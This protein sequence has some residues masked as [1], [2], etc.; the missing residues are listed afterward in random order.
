MCIIER[1]S[2]NFVLLKRAPTTVD[3]LRGIPFPETCAYS[4]SQ[5]SD[6]EP[7]PSIKIRFG[8]HHHNRQGSNRRTEG[9][10]S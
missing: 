3:S 6:P 1:T 7:S 10:L 9:K 2:T 4:G 5:V 8:Y